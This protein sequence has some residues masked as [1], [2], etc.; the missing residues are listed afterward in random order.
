MNVAAC[1]LS[2]TG[3]QTR[4]AEF[5]QLFGE[6]VRSVKRPDPSWLQ[7]EL[8]PGPGPAGRTAELAAAETQCCSFFTFTLTAA[9]GSLIL[10]IRVPAA[11]AAVLDMLAERAAASAAD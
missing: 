7:L 1:T 11:Q 3:R 10:D 5:S 8:K 9:A 6:T 2:E 4:A